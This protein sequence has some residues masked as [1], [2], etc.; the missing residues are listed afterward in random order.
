[1]RVRRQLR[2][3]EG[4]AAS[5]PLAAVLA[6]A[7]GFSTADAAKSPDDVAIA[8]PAPGR[9][10]LSIAAQPISDA[11]NEFAR[12]SGLQ[13][14]FLASEQSRQ[15]VSTAISG[16]FEPD[17]A[18][19]RLLSSTGLSYKYLDARSVAIVDPSAEPQASVR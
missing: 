11:L 16:T 13:V 19:A 8:E 1:M 2:F 10:K 17:V 12:Q 14:F 7:F 5:M 4:R 18:L 15:L 3:L 9:L 6:I